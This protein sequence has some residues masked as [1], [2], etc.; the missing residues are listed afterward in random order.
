VTDPDVKVHLTSGCPLCGSKDYHKHTQKD[1]RALIDRS[2]P[3][4]PK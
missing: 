2:D 3:F 4:R 1:W